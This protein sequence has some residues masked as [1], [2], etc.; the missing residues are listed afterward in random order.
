MATHFTALEREQLS[1]W[2]QMK[3]SK[4]E[5]ARRL[6]RDESTIFRE[7]K[8]NSARRCYGHRP[9]Y[10]AMAAQQ[11]S[12]QRKHQRRTRKLERPEIRR[13]VEQH[14][15]MY[16]SPDQISGRLQH[17]FAD[18][19]RL[20]VSPQA[21]Y[22]WLRNH[23]H[24]RQLCPFL[25]HFRVKIKIRSS[26]P[27]AAAIANRPQIIERRER[28]GDWEG[29]TIVGVRRSGA[30]VSLVERKTGYAVLAK[31]D[32]L[33]SDPVEKVIRRRLRLLPK[34]C[35]HSITFDNGGEF[36]QHPRLTKTLGL[37]VYFA[38]PRCPWQRGTNENTNGLVRQFLPKGSCFRDLHH[39]AVAR[40][41][42][43]LNERPRKRLGYLTPKE[44]LANASHAMLT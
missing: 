17:D 30:V 37:E 25:R 33:C 18:Q 11:L 38:R 2:L 41:Q 5:I 9:S 8:R 13:Y 12:D 10:S 1:A 22:Q 35:R 14:L 4:A 3:V 32:R 43:S 42:S 39:T 29:D 40:I 6:G 27:A 44:A 26:R 23:D 24:A 19:P 31:V 28:V 36:A 7:L 20:R 15:K 34:S 16:W 21:I